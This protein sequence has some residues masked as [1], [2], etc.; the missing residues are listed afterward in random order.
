MRIDNEKAVHL[1]S[2]LGKGALIEKNRE[3]SI[4][5]GERSEIG[6]GKRGRLYAIFVKHDGRYDNSARVARFDEKIS[7]EELATL[8][9]TSIEQSVAL[10][11]V[12]L[13]MRK[14]P[15]ITNPITNPDLEQADFYKPVEQKIDEV[16]DLSDFAD[17]FGESD[18]EE[19]N[20]INETSADENASMHDFDN[21]SHDLSGE[22]NVVENEE[23]FDFDDIDE[24]S[25]DVNNESDNEEINEDKS[26]DIDN[27]SDEDDF[28]ADDEY[29][30][31]E[32]G[33][34]VAMDEAVDE[35]EPDHKEE[36]EEFDSK[37]DKN[38]DVL[39][40]KEHLLPSRPRVSVAD[41]S[42]LYQLIGD[43]SE[44]KEKMARI[45][46]QLADMDREIITTFYISALSSLLA[47]YDN[48]IEK[49]SE[50]IQIDKRDIML[51]LY[52]RKF[53]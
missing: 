27:V 22:D 38:L 52:E 48:D 17:M 4:Q 31:E 42:Y 16:D 26:D 5:I 19:Q 8:I 3:I 46:D 6:I 2:Y 40:N 44:I 33:M 29:Y 43:E 21:E 12:E 1:A 47:L 24:E 39:L 10:S 51:A 32:N 11:N 13:D 36:R 53:I 50:D 35:S 30:D 34:A 23:G 41:N 7:I 9:K 18:E 45:C 25:E 28:A 20:D 15:M 49:L 14:V 37:I